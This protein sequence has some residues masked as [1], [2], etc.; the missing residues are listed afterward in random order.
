MPCE[1]PAS[2]HRAALLPLAAYFTH[3]CCSGSCSHF[4]TVNTRSSNGT[5]LKKT[6]SSWETWLVRFV[7]GG[8]GGG[9]GMLLLNLLLTHG[10][11]IS[12][13]EGA[14]GSTLSA[15]ITGSVLGSD[16]MG[17]QCVQQCCCCLGNL[18]DNILICSCYVCGSR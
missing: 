5:L 3:R 13:A 1:Y 4:S 14:G 10:T 15:D 11:N 2:A 8:G 9:G 6:K 16:V 17:Q 7:L 18:A 12:H